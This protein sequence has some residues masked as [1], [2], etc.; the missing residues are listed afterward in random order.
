MIPTKLPKKMI[1]MTHLNHLLQMIRLTQQH[2]NTHLQKRTKTKHMTRLMIPPQLKKIHIIQ[3]MKERTIQQ[4][5]TAP[6]YPGYMEETKG[7]DSY[8]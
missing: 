8:T 7:N 5:I 1:H 4:T 3:V 2:K 6:A